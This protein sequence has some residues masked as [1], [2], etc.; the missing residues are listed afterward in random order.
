MSSYEIF[1]NF[2][3]ISSISKTEVYINPLIANDNFRSLNEIPTSS[4]LKQVINDSKTASE[5]IPRASENLLSLKHS[6][7]RL[8][9][10]YSDGTTKLFSINKKSPHSFLRLDSIF[11]YDY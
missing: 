2:Y 10:T 1:T 6:S 3:A 11:K 9:I 8:K 4:L 5:E 7:E